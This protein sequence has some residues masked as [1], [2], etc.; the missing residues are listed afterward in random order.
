MKEMLI[1][2]DTKHNK[3]KFYKLELSGD[4]VHVEYGRVGAN[5]QKASF[6]GGETMFKRKMRQKLT[7]GYI[8]SSIDLGYLIS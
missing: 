8:K 6:S 4:M 2:V 5:A 7:K 1:F 3:N